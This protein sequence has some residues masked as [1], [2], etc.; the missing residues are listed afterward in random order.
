MSDNPAT[1]EEMWKS[2]EHQV[3]VYENRSS[4]TLDDDVK[5]SVVLRET[6]GNSKTIC[7]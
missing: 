2:W 6:H 7:W 1:F 5:I 3:D 4:S